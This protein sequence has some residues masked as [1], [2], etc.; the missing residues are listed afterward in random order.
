MSGLSW[1]T[2]GLGSVQGKGYR[3][4]HR[5]HPPLHTLEERVVIW[6]ARENRGPV[7]WKALQQWDDAT[8]TRLREVFKS[9]EE[10]EL[11]AV[12]KHK[13]HLLYELI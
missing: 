2:Y 8:E 13:N 4:K 5:S 9:L 6:L 11:V 7:S 12:S 10:Q 1:A 3:K